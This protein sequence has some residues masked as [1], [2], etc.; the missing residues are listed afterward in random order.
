MKLPAHIAAKIAETIANL[1]QQPRYHPDWEA[2]EYGAIAL[3]G[4][5]GSTW[6]LRPDGE[7]FDVDSDFEK[8]LTPLA[9]EFHVTAIVAG[10][11][12]YPW[13]R[14]LLPRRPANALDCPR[15]GGGGVIKAAEDLGSGVFC[16]VCDALGWLPGG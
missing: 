13:L 8:P 9:E 10:C 3:M 7:L 15:C 16:C 1:P 14:E 11:E 6:L 4:T 2:R 5:I 12:R